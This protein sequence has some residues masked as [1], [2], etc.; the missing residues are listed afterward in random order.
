VN[1]CPLIRGV[2]DDGIV[3]AE[4]FET[5]TELGMAQY[6][7]FQIRPTVGNALFTVPLVKGWQLFDAASRRCSGLSRRSRFVMSHASGKIEIVGVDDKR[8]FLRYHRAL[9]PS[10][11]SRVMVARRDEQAIWFDQL[12]LIN[13]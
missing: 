3:L 6:Y 10:D 12:E 9:D 2:N 7:L 13:P 8:I 1:Q 5:T 11:E 4:L